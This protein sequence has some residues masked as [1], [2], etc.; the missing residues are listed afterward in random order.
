MT[1]DHEPPPNID[2][3]PC[4]HRWRAS[5]KDVPSSTPV[6]HVCMRPIANGTH[7]GVHICTCGAV[8]NYS[9]D[10]P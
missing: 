5:R 2:Q 3:R 8:T 6:E 10:R 7:M 4:C 1:Q 9:G